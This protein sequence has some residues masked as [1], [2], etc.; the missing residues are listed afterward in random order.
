MSKE[1][2]LK[3]PVP[4][5][6]YPYRFEGITDDEACFE[7]AYLMLNIELYAEKKYKPLIQQLLDGDISEI[8]VEYLEYCLSYARDNT[9]RYTLETYYQI[10]GKK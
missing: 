1:K 3:G 8:P 10:H 6:D 5:V 2:I 9:W 4:A 7:Q